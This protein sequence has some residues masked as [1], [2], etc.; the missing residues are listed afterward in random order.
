[1]PVQIMASVAMKQINFNLGQF[2]SS[3]CHESFF[4]NKK[5]KRPFE[6]SNRLNYNWRFYFCNKEFATNIKRLHDWY[7]PIKMK[8]KFSI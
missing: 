8:K 3:I 7:V 2:R 5:V 1:M 4:Q 6:N